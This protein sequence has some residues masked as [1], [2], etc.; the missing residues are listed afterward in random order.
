MAEFTAS[1][2]KDLRERTGAGIVDCKTALGECDGDIDKATEYLRKKGLAAASKRA[3]RIAAEGLVSS[4]IHMGGKIG[5]LLEV[6]CET[7][8]VAKN[9]DFKQL[10][11]DLCMQ[12]AA[13]NPQFV[14]KDEVPAELVAK[15][16]EIAE[17]KARTEGKPEK[18]LPK[19]AEGAVQ[20]WMKEVVLLDQPFVKDPAKDVQTLVNEHIAK[21]GEKIAVRRFVR[22]ELGEGLEKRKSDIAAEVAKELESA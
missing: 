18:I 11:H 13:S 20:K 7:D 21:I 22:Y 9:E 2:I 1:T 19:I 12:I 8:F 16:K 10:V 3:G 5:V 4:Y 14:T 6:N 15:E 17:E